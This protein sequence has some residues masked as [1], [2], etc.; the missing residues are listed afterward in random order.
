M[1]AGNTE[2]PVTTS[3]EAGADLLVMA[4]H[5][6]YGLPVT[7]SRGSNNYGSYHFPEKRIPPMI[8]NAP[9]NKPMPVYGEG[10]NVRTWLYVEDHCK[11][12]VSPRL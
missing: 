9:A 6:T 3:S 4:Y 2:S 7:I 8:A 5:R 11:A 12:L 1:P 10:L